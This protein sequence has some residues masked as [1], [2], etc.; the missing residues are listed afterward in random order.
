MPRIEYATHEAQEGHTTMQT[1]AF[2]QFGVFDLETTGVDYE[3]DRIVTAYFGILEL[4]GTFSI[5]KSW[6]VNPGI[7]IPEGAAAVHGISNEVAERDGVNP[8]EAIQ[9]LVNS[10]ADAVNAGLPVSAYNGRFDFTML[11]RE[12]RR[13]LGRALPDA[14]TKPL[15]AIDPYVLDKQVDKYRKGPRKLVVTTAHYGIDLGDAA[16]DAEADAK[17]TGLVARAILSRFDLPKN[18]DE[19][20]NMQVIWARDQAAGLQSYFR[21]SG[22]PNAVIEGEWPMVSFVE[23][24]VPDEDADRGVC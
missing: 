5:S 21:R 10:I 16:H 14:F 8:A 22:Q 13:H 12:S 7:P 20:H 19:L 4:D 18:I 24:V 23:T 11:D 6:L 2:D 3:N 9:E 1:Q 15:R 17:A